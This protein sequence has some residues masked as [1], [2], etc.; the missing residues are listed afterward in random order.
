[1]AALFCS[2]HGGRWEQTQIGSIGISPLPGKGAALQ[3]EGKRF[4]G[5]NLGS[6]KIKQLQGSLVACCSSK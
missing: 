3:A 1:M 2:R 5:V 4:R 6:C